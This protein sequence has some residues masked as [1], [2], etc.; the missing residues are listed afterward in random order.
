M[1]W[2]C[3]RLWLDEHTMR[4]GSSTMFN[5]E[6]TSR[7]VSFPVHGSRLF[8]NLEHHEQKLQS[9]PLSQRNCSVAWL[10]M[11][12]CHFYGIYCHLVFVVREACQA[13]GTFILLEIIWAKST[14]CFWTK[15]SFCVQWFILS[16][17]NW[18][19][20]VHIFMCVYADLWGPTYVVAHWWTFIVSMK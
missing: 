7:I 3:G 8:G 19:W 5:S 17:S 12:V 18:S 15:S 11:S 9:P 16:A 10:I 13:T 1:Q 6:P 20:I 14:R 2:I 4:S